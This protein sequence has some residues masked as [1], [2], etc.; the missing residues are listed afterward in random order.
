MTKNYGII[1]GYRSGLE[2]KI[3]PI[4]DAAGV[5][6][7]YET[8]KIKYS[9]NKECTYTP[10]FPII[11]KSGYQ[12]FL[13]S[14]GR[15]L[16]SDRQKHIMIKEQHPELDIRFLFT[17]AKAKIS[18]VSKTTYAQWCDKHGFKWAHKVIPTEWFSEGDK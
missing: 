3:P 1:H 10:D 15:F 14:K 6:W 8:V 4:L 13:E 18:K 9:V 2:E 11:N 17:N 5:K 16:T 12:W 7:S